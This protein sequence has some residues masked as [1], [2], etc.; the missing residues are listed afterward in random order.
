[1]TNRQIARNVK[2][3]RRIRQGWFDILARNGDSVGA[4]QHI[5]SINCK[6]ELLLSMWNWSDESVD[7]PHE[8]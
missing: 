7:Y 2:E 4:A 8:K 6:I 1:M 3:F 5:L